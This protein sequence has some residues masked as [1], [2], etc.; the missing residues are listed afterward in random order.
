M[1]GL[2]PSSALY[3][4]LC[5]SGRDSRPKCGAEVEAED[6]P[7]INKTGEKMYYSDKDAQG[8]S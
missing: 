2:F 6:T 8:A 7:P 4:S 3:R 1:K 5:N